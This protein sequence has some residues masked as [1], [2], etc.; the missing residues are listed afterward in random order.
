MVAL[1]ARPNEPVSSAA[2]R[3]INRLSDFLFVA[4]RYA[5][6]KGKSEVLWVRG[7]NR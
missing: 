5:N 2:L 3:Y 6:E 1:A 4:A 7:Q